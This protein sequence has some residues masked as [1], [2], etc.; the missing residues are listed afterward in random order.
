MAGGGEPDLWPGET[1]LPAVQAGSGHA[2]DAPR[3]TNRSHGRLAGVRLLGTAEHRFQRAGST[4]GPSWGGRAG[5]SYLGDGQACHTPARPTHRLCVLTKRCGERSCS[6]EN[7]GA[8]WQR[9]ETSSGRQP[10]QLGE[11]IDDGQRERSSVLPCHR[12][13]FESH[14]SRM[15]LECHVTRKLV[16][17]QQKKSD[18]PHSRVRSPVRTASW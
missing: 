1:K 10:W 17:C 9:N 3:G 12:F 6:L 18:G 11:Q 15:R 5:A 8:N 13:P 4:H 16:K 7:E 14:S 2:R